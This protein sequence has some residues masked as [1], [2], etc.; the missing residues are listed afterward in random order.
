MGTVL[1]LGWHESES[2]LSCRAG[3]QIRCLGEPASHSKSGTGHRDILYQKHLLCTRGWAGSG[4][5]RGTRQT[6]SRARY[7]LVREIIGTQ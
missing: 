4:A 2:A 7:R 3:P 5:Q 1:S 6:Q